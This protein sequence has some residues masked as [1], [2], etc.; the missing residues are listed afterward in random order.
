MARLLEDY[1]K[2]IVPELKQT[3]GRANSHSIPKLQKIV[4]SMGVGEAVNDRKRLDQA[5]DQLTQLAGQ[6]A[7]IC[8]P[9]SMSLLFVKFKLSFGR[10]AGSNMMSYL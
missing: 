7:Q 2:R 4:V 5:A 3:L 6:K 1:N 8:K 10:P 9:E